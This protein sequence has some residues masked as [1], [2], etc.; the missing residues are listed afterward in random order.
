MDTR[1]LVVDDA[2]FDTVVEEALIEAELYS[3]DVLPAP[4]FR[5][6][7]QT[8]WHMC[9]D[10][11]RPPDLALLTTRFKTGGSG[12]RLLEFMQRHPLLRSIPVIM[13]SPGF[14]L[15]EEHAAYR[16]GAHCCLHRAADVPEI[17]RAVSRAIGSQPSASRRKWRSFPW[18]S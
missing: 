17:A 9:R 6:A 4:S 3:S 7:A 1:V 13:L 12:Y 18:S 11:D 10:A 15:T 2:G 14:S 5:Q 16:R 8:L